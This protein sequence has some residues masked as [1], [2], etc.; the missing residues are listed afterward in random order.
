MVTRRQTTA[1][2]AP[3]KPAATTRKATTTRKAA[4]APPAPVKPTRDVTEY[5][6]KAPTG[7][8]KAFAKWI[9][10][11]VGFDPNEAT[12]KRAAFL[13]GV[14]IA[15]AARPAFT[16]SD[17]L[18]EWR[19]E[20]GEAK[21][22]PKPKN[23]PPATTT[24]GRKAAAPVVEEVEEDDTEEFDRDALAEELESLTLAKLKAR[25]K[26]DYAATVAD[27]KGLTKDE[28]LEWI[29][30]TAEEA[31]FGDEEDEE[32]DDEDESEE[33]TDDEEGDEEEE[34][35]DDTEEEEEKPAPRRGRRTASTPAKTPAKGRARSTK[36]GEDDK[37]LF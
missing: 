34:E 19:E 29:L 21:R 9:V 2:K 28:T 12:S 31:E 35:E 3:V 16:D 13:A 11:F 24:R 33:D 15:T 18:A 10:E 37:F 8:H 5:A 22:G 32:G 23:A 27:L 4:A 25:A 36:S 30:D 14:S 7:Y 26:S 17:F 1:R 6:D 20:S